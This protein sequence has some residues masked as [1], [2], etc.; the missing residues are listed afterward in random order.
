VDDYRGVDM[1][2]VTVPRWG[3][4]DE[5]ARTLGVDKVTIRRMISRGEIEARRYGPRLIR[6]NMLTLADAGQPLQHV[7]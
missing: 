3:T 6:V 1:D 2:Q 5:A 7:Y 4:M